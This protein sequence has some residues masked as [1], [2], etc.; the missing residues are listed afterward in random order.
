MRKGFTLIEN[1]MVIVLI[2][3]LFAGVSVYI[4]ESINS[5]VFM[6]EQKELLLDARSALTRM[7]RELKSTNR[8][9]NLTVHASSEVTFRDVSNVSVTFRQDGTTLKRNTDILADNLAVPGGLTLR[10][11]D[12][13]GNETGNS[14]LIE[15]IRIR[16]TI[17]NGLNKFVT[18][19]SVGIRMRRL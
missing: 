6:S 1:I 14:N 10:Y 17:V 2:G 16:L 11:L 15:A 5:W 4:Q 12:E 7:T 19:S 9:V 8:N 3:I 18:E 13:N